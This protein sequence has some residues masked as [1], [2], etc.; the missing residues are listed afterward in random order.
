MARSSRYLGTALAGLALTAFAVAGTATTA[1]A[2]TTQPTPITN[3]CI[4]LVGTPDPCAPVP[5]QHPEPVD[6][7]CLRVDVEPLHCPYQP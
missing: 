4:H 7:G 5:P 1:S 6:P 3:P 2:I